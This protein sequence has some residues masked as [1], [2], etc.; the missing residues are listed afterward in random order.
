M[1]TRVRA[2]TCTLC[3]QQP[4]HRQQVWRRQPYNGV[5][6]EVFPDWGP[7]SLGDRKWNLALRKCACFHA[8]ACARLSYLSSEH[9]HE[10][11]FVFPCS[12]FPA[13]PSLPAGKCWRLTPGFMTQVL[14]VAQ[15]QDMFGSAFENSEQKQRISMC[16][17]R[18]VCVRFTAPAYRCGNGC[19]FKDCFTQHLSPSCNQMDEIHQSTPSQ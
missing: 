4:P 17:A 5:S 12:H 16:V 15:R 10:T 18:G 13:F 2:C 9:S 3:A 8:H 7:W 14:Y 1:H 19:A 11:T 6:G